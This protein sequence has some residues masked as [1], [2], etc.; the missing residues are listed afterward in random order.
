MRAASAGV[1][2]PPAAKLTTGRRPSRLT[3]WTSSGAPSSA[4]GG[5]DFVVGHVL[6]AADL[7]LDGAHVADGL[8]DVA[9]AGFA[10]GADHGGAFAD[11]AEGFTEVAAAADEGDGEGVLIDVV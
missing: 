6:D 5:V 7:V 3:C 10:L 4:G 1:A 9:G 8:D 11:A 2:T